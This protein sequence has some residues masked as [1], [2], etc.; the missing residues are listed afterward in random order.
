MIT[1]SM[2]PGTYEIRSNG[3]NGGKILNY[4][5][6]TLGYLKVEGSPDFHSKAV[7]IPRSPGKPPSWL[8]SHVSVLVDVLESSYIVYIPFLR[9]DT[10]PM[11]QN[12]RIAAYRNIIMSERQSG[13]APIFYLNGLTWLQQTP[14]S[15]DEGVL[16]T[17]EEWLVAVTNDP[18]NNLEPHVFH[19]HTVGIHW[20]FF[21]LFLHTQISHL[22]SLLLISIYSF[23]S[24][25]LQHRTILS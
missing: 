14:E 13:A 17:V 19:V 10:H 22:S 12:Q 2:T 20:G 1:A 24:L 9:G 21:F 4:P 8:N 6:V 11:H 5:P 3:Y 25:S 18:S 23:S 7:K 15:I 16:G